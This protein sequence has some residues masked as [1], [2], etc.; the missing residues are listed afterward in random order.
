MMTESSARDGAREG[1]FW[2][3]LTLA[4]IVSIASIGYAAGPERWAA[5]RAPVPFGWY[6]LVVVHAVANLFLSWYLARMLAQWRPVLA[7]RWKAL[8]WA[9]AGLAVAGMTVVAGVSIQAL[10]E[11][12]GAGYIVRLV[13]RIVW[14]T[15]LQVP[16]CMAGLAAGGGT[17][18]SR[19]HSIP[20]GHLLALAAVS[21]T[22]L[23]AHET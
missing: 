13:A 16:W 21:Y 20:T 1:P 5:G 2:A 19:R 11:A 18:E 9:M 10:V 14:C 17:R 22:H 8:V 6:R 7:M 4:T 23:R 12:P 15:V 3:G